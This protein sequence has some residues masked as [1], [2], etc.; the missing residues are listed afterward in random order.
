MY[1]V[2]D[3][4]DC[5]LN[6]VPDRLDNRVV[7][8]L[9]SSTECIQHS[10]HTGDQSIRHPVP[11]SLDSSLNQIPDRLDEHVIQPLEDLTYSIQNCLDSRE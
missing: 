5:V 2:P 10:L 4:F 3:R 1:E 11:D 9:E 8:P 6:S 7:D